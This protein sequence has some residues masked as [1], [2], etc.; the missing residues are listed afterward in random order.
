MSCSGRVQLEPR[1]IDDLLERVPALEALRPYAKPRRMRAR[2]PGFSTLVQLV[3][4][5]AVSQASASA[6]WGRVCREVPAVEPAALAAL[7]SE[8]LRA[9][10][11]S[12]SKAA[13]ML[14][15]A[16]A[17]LE[18]RLSLEWLASAPDEE[19]RAMLVSLRGVG[20]WTA[21]LYLLLALGRPDV[22][23][24]HDLALREALRD[25][26]DLE[27]RPTIQAADALGD[28]HRPHRSTLTILLWE[29]YLARRARA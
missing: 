13:C 21:D 18:G 20:R 9:L 15:I 8:A 16:D 5:Q 29:H 25:V 22:W 4:E 7:G 12:R 17:V 28:P 2:P 14:E 23:P 19:A 27:A 3:A 24:V 10:G 1:I 26:L 11:L 6:V